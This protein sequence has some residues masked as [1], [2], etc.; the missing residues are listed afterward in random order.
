MVKPCLTTSDQMEAMRV[1]LMSHYSSSAAFGPVP[2]IDNDSHDGVPPD[3]F[4][5]APLP[6]HV[7]LLG[8]V[9]K[10]DR[11]DLDCGNRRRL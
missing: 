3:E 1:L 7:L 10:L 8:D 4:K 2:N 9:V 6:R 11:R 5:V